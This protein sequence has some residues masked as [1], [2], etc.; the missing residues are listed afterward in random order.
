[1]PIAFDDADTSAVWR[2]VFERRAMHA[3][4]DHSSEALALLPNAGPRVPALLRFIRGCGLATMGLG[5]ALP[6]R[7]FTSTSHVASALRLT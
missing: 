2:V 7:A 3:S 5:Q 6:G 4:G 1:M